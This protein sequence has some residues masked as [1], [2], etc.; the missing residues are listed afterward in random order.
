MRW[1]SS[2]NEVLTQVPEVEIGLLSVI[3]SSK[4]RTL[5]VIFLFFT[6][7]MSSLVIFNNLSGHKR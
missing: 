7:V 5:E 3:L 4:L 6:L 1:N 2:C